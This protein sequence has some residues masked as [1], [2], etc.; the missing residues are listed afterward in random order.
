MERWVCDELAQPIRLM[1]TPAF[2]SCGA[3]RRSQLQESEEL[4]GQA[5]RG[6]LW[7]DEREAA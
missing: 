3:W 6:H 5:W 7:R 2:P 4:C 1:M